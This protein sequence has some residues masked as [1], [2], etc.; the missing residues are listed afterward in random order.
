MPRVDYYRVLGVSRDVTDDD[1]KK[2]YRKLVFQHHPDRNPNNTKAEE[3]IREINSAYEILGDPES[4]RTYDRLHWGE[5]PRNEAVDPSFILDEMEKKLFDEGRK[6]VFAVLMKML[7]RVKAELAM[8]R[9]RTVAQQGYDSFKVP[10]VEARA[11]EVMDEFVTPEMEKRKQRLLEVALQMM[12]SQAVVARGDEGGI[13][14]L[15]GQLEEVFRKGRIKGFIA[16]LELLY[17]R[18]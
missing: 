9:E 13:R 2:A 1:I 3:K 15:R 4:R 14:A 11:A 8:V 6:E 18:R 17:E 7:P 5:E 10:I 12:V 16:A